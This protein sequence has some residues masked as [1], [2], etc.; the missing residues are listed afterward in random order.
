MLKL[1]TFGQVEVCA[2]YINILRGL[3]SRIKLSCL[4]KE[5]RDR[6]FWKTLC[7]INYLAFPSA[8]ILFKLL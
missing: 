4:E 7:P 6:E 1:F 5:A 8:L 2:S 3:E